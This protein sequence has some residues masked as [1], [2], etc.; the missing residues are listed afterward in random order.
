MREHKYKVWL[1][2]EQRMYGPYSL[3]EWLYKCDEGNI[4]AT[5][6]GWDGPIIPADWVEWLQYTGLKDSKRTKEY[7]DGQEI[8][9][10]DIVHEGRQN[11]RII[12]DKEYARFICI[13]GI[14]TGGLYLQQMEIIGNKY[15]NPELLE[16]IE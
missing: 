13:S 7:P 1:E 14:G 16:G 11:G 12:W 15:E 3:E 10:G 2:E 8:Y 6:E 9:E 4:T 5:D